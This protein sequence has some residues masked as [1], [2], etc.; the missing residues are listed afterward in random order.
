MTRIGIVGCGF[1]SSLYMKS[2]PLYDDLNLVGAYD[3]KPDRLDAFCKHYSATPYDTLES[4]TQDV[5]LIVNLTTPEQHFDVSAYALRAGKS[6]YSE[7]P[8]TCSEEQS[9]ELIEIAADNNTNILGAP[10]GH[11]SEMA[12]TVAKCL[13]DGVIG[14]VYAVYAEMDD[15]QMHAV[16]YEKWRN[17]FGVEWPAKNEFEIGSTNEHAGYSICVLQRWFG[18]A[19]VKGVVNHRCIEDKIIPLHKK[20]ADFSCAVL[21]YDNNIVARVTCSIVA[22]KDRQIRI[23]GE[24]GLITIKDTWMYESPITIRKWL[25]IRRKTILSPVKEKVPLVKTSFPNAPKTAAAQMDFCRGIRQLANL[26][27]SDRALMENYLEVNAIVSQMNGESVSEVQYPWIVLGTGN[28]AKNM[29]E[30]L[31]RNAYPILAVYSQQAER[32]THLQKQLNAKHTYNSLDEIPQADGKTIAYVASV[33]DKH[34]TQVKA[35]LSKGYDVLCEKPL[36]MLTAQTE[37]LFA[38]A[39]RS[40]LKLQENLWSLFLPSAPEINKKVEDHKQITLSFTAGIPYAPDA[41]QWQPEAGGCL[42]DLGIYPLAWAVYFLGDITDFEVTHSKTEHNIVS[43]VQLVTQHTSGKSA[44]IITGFN[45]TEQYIKVGKEYFTPI[46]APEFRSTVS[47]TFVR[48]VREKLM[49]P[50]Y[51]AKDPYAYIL[52]QMNSAATQ[53]RHPS[54]ASIHVAGIMEQIHNQLV[55]VSEATTAASMMNRTSAHTAP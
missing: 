44:V 24:L 9:R 29:G 39:E 12:E 41:R 35:L 38:L 50:E 25:T 14:K 17:D 37:E 30:C 19:K 28:M 8:L 20:T 5:D 48:K 13:E 40:G 55:P 43:E 15:G 10:C 51:P 32:A 33:N 11:L 54:E 27:H 31:R 2:L 4:L 34:Y 36:T 42:Y 7:K 18:K 45:S 23:F 53:S 47:N 16:A 46:Y 26:S 52:D 3:I 21:E 22:P 1:V 6:V 49:P